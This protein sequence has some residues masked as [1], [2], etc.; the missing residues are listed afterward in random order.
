MTMRE[1]VQGELRKAERELSDLHE[2]INRLAKEVSR[3]AANARTNM[4]PGLALSD[5]TRDIARM[6]TWLRE[7]QT[8]IALFRWLLNEDESA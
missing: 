4:N 8:Q 2:D 7:T 1:K 5:A 3:K 6:G